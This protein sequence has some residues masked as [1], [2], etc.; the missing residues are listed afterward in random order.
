M[1]DVSIN[2]NHL[3]ET[4]VVFVNLKGALDSEKAIDFYDFI[5]AEIIKGF[6]KFVVDCSNLDYI[7][8]AGISIMIRLLDGLYAVEIAAS[9]IIFFILTSTCNMSGCAGLASSITRAE[10][11]NLLLSPCCMLSKPPNRRQSAT[12]NV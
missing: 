3:S 6:R 9:K 12:P 11:F 2:E 8:S 7:S 4:Q 10:E 5:N 1:L